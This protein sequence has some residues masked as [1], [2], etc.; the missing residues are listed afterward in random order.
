M[1]RWKTAAAAVAVAA[2]TLTGC[3]AQG[4]DTNSTPGGTLTL[5]DTLAPTTLDAAGSGWAVISP[6]YQAAY[7][8]LLRATTDGKI[9]PFL[10]QKW[11]YNKDKTVLTLNLR[12]G[13]TF[14]DGSKLT[15]AVV[16]T[17]L[18]RFQKGTSPDASFLKGI[19]SIDAPDDLTVVLNLSAPDPAML[20]YLARD[21]GLI[22]SGDAI[23]KD[24]KSL[25]TNPIGSGP[26]VLDTKE[27]VIGAS[28]VYTK[29][30]NYWN[31]SVQHYDKVVIK[32]MADATAAINAMKSGEVNGVRLL[33]NN[34]LEEIKGAGWTIN[35]NE[36]NVFG[37]LL[38]DRGASSNK[39]LGDVRVRQ[40]INYAFDRKSLLKALQFDNGTVTEQVF[41]KRSAAFDAGLDTHYSFDPQKSKQL[42]SEAGYPNG[43][44]LTMPSTASVGATTW[45][46]IGQQLGD[47]GIK[48]EFTDA[49]SNFV[50]DILAPKYPAAWIGLE[51][52]SD[53]QLTQFMISPTAVWNP[54]KYSDPKVD[55]F[56]KQIQYGDE[57]AQ[58]SASKQ[59]NKYIVEQA[60][61][62]PW[63]RPNNSF[64]TDA[65]TSVT[66]LPS[67]VF[68]AIYDFEPKK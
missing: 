9:E 66:M 42:L 40:A 46:L 57:S 25:A 33:N 64:A 5:A 53:W 65:Q 50:S 36:M 60:W 3:A 4:P 47:V 17:N 62:A 31:A 21:S 13:V 28:Y 43:F 58:Q 19:K 48:V 22:A 11:S 39:A 37:M 27:T 34:N 30:P 68:P 2:L 1:F 55:E 6:Y 14:S 18:E 63:Y 41:P 61:F 8:T 16:K 35:Q 45:T 67:N 12:S 44:T 52:Q 23:A 26:Y 7:D 49:A 38:L 29:N 56:I 15:A 59:L 51:Q 10:A 20:N 54:F 32:V 24:P